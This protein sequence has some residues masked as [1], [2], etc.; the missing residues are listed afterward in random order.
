MVHRQSRPATAHQKNSNSNI[1]FHAFTNLS[2]EEERLVDASVSDGEPTVSVPADF[3][4]VSETSIVSCSTSATE[5]SEDTSPVLSC[6]SALA[7]PCCEAG[8]SALTVGCSVARGCDEGVTGSGSCSTSLIFGVF[9][10]GTVTGGTKACR[11]CRGAVE[12]V[13]GTPGAALCSD[14]SLP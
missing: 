6:G 1:V 14:E 10:T 4:E 11:D 12:N 2:S 13:P 3:S 8:L 9:L 7:M 5:D